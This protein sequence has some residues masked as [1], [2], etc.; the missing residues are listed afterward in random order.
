MEEGIIYILTNSAMPGLVKIGM[1]T[2]DEVEVRMNELYTTGV[3]VPFECAFAGK[4]ESLRKVE[5]ALHIAFGPQRINAKREFF[6]IEAI[7]AIEIMKL[8]CSEDVTPQVQ[9]ELDKVDE[10]SKDAGKRLKSRRPNLNFEEMQIPIGSKIHS[11]L[12]GEFC[13]IHSTNKVVFKEEVM[14]LT[15]ATKLAL[16]NDYNVAPCP[17]WTFD[18]ENLGDI[19]RNTYDSVESE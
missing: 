4:T 11:T 5:R 6:Q 7:Q 13:I 19:Y 8:L 12:N 1:T 2:R 10:V 9:Q 17:H 18:G 14:S 16:N 15:K 3:P